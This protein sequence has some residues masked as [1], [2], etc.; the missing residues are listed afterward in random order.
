MVMSDQ[1]AQWQEIASRAEALALK[2]KL[3]VEQVGDDAGRDAAL[4]RF[5]TAVDDAFTAAGNAVRDE[6][7]RADVREMG[8]LMIEAITTAVDRAGDQA[9]E[10][11]DR[12]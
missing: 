5:R 1:A 2:L 7:V 6:A 11:L 3:H 8:R 9:R 4:D 10:H 12:R